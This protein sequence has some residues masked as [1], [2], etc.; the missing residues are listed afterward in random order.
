MKTKL[1]ETI[2]RVI[3]VLTI[4]QKRITVSFKQPLVTEVP[5]AKFAEKMKIRVY[6]A[7]MF[8][9]VFIVVKTFL[10]VDALVQLPLTDNFERRNVVIELVADFAPVLANDVTLESKFKTC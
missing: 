5:G 9:Y 10:A 6:K 4:V 2:R 7:E 8:F 1:S 3:A